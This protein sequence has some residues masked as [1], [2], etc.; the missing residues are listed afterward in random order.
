[1]RARPVALRTVHL[2]IEGLVQGVSYRASA[3]DEATRLG[4]TG[5]VR[6][7]SNGDVEALAAGPSNAVEQF[8]TW[9]KRGPDEARVSNVTMTE[10]APQAGLVGFE[11][12][13]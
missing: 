5:W 11:V 12:R 13:R 3:R 6:N 7:L 9:C 10:A 1:M 4:I 8:V 2:R